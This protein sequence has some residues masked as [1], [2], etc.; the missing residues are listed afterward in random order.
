MLDVL[1][2][3][4]GPAGVALS[5]A[6]ARL[7]LRTGLVAPRPDAAWPTYGMWADETGLPG[8]RVP[9]WAGRL[10]DR[11][12]LVLDNA[13]A[14]T[15]LSHP[16]VAVV[17]DRVRAVHRAGSGYRVRLASGRT[18]DAGVVVNATGPRAARIAQTAFGV[19]LPPGE[20]DAGTAVVMDWTPA[21][22]YA[23]AWP[24]FRYAV[25]VADGVLVEETS[26]AHRPGLPIAELRARLAAR[27]GRSLA[28]L[29]TET[30]RVPLDGG[31]PRR[32][33]IVPFGAAAGLVHPATGYS[34]ADAVR[35]APRLA[36]ALA[37]GADPWPVLWPTRARAV[38]AL[39]RKGLRTLLALTP[40]QVP[41]FFALFFALPE[42][43]QRAYLSGRADL[44]G[45]TAAMAAMFRAAPRPLRTAMLGVQRSMPRRAPSGRST[46]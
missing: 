42:H 17:A 18:L 1:V 14:R 37:T 5:G 35:L 36:H 15:A 40:A 16:G 2:A 13:A 9:A 29:R 12:Y 8:T 10:L 7:G 33:P 41:E 27:L 43:L 11:D 31:L 23:G 46:S 39:R 24:T 25:P 32:G 45:T 38:Y 4:A 28:G 20:A 34:V 21:P 22:G 44:P 19:V 26:L 30:V 3:G 6:C